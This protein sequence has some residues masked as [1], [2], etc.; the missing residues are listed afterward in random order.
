MSQHLAESGQ[1]LKGHMGRTVS[2]DHK[3]VQNRTVAPDILAQRR[4]L[5]LGSRVPVVLLCAETHGTILMLKFKS[6]RFPNW[7]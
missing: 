5:G 3:C 6:I 1:M 7:S 2:E 4:V